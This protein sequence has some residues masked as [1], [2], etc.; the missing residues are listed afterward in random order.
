[1]RGVVYG[2]GMAKR[3]RKPKAPRHPQTNVSWGPESIDVL[4]QVKSLSRRYAWKDA[5][6][7]RMLA[8]LGLRAMKRGE[9]LVE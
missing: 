7:V 9:Q 5:H 1:M 8:A 3:K 2:W 4:K 6:T